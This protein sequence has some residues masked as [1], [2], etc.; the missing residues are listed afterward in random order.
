MNGALMWQFVKWH[1]LIGDRLADWFLRKP[2]PEPS[3]RDKELE[4]QLRAAHLGG[5]SRAGPARF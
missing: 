4:K 5:V 3:A 1:K 2:L